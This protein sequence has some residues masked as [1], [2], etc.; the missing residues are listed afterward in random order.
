[1]PK[2]PRV[3]IPT[4]RAGGTSRSAWTPTRSP[5]GASRSPAG[6]SARRRR[7]VD[8]RRELVE[9]VDRGQLRSTPAGTT[10]YDL[11]DLYLDGLDADGR[12]S[13]K[14]RFDYR[15]SADDYVRPHLGHHPGAGRHARGDPG[16]AAQAHHGG[17]HQADGRQGRQAAAPQGPVAQHRPAGPVAAGRGVQAGHAHRDGRQQPDRP[18]CPDPGRSGRSPSTGARSRPG[19]SWA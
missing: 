8:A 3:C 5:V 9:K 12:L 4:A 19:S 17:R 11:L 16:L 7:R 10:V 1:M 13:E 2:K 6:G 15:H 14:T 18:G